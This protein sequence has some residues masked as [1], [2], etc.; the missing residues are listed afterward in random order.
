MG[1]IFKN[2]AEMH[3]IKPTPVPF[4]SPV[5]ATYFTSSGPR[6]PCRNANTRLFFS[7]GSGKIGINQ[8]FREPVTIPISPDFDVFTGL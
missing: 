5:F 4:F 8:K 2:T 1:P 7:G 6:K 3:V